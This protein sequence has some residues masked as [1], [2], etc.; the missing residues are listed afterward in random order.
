MGL[1]ERERKLLDE[2]ERSLQSDGIE[3]PKVSDAAPT[4]GRRMLAGLLISAL[5]FF[6]LLASVINQIAPL[7]LL[8]FLTMGFGLVLASSRKK[9]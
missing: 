3:E 2:L 5:G 8:C 7:G 9:L 6:G 4:W 1:S